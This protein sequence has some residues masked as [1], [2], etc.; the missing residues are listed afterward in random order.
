MFSPSAECE[1][2]GISQ[3]LRSWGG[4]CFLCVEF[5]S[6]VCQAN[7]A[8]VWPLVQTLSLI[9]LPC[10][11]FSRRAWTKYKN[12]TQITISKPT[13][14]EIKLHYLLSF[15]GFQLNIDLIF[16]LQIF[17]DF[18]INYSPYWF[19]RKSTFLVFDCFL[20][21]FSLFSQ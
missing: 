21:H 5:L 14:S 3:L 8:L 2:V 1:Q 12:I 18:N 10:W 17:T 11:L 16:F 4:E 7:L 15:K 19:G 20:M 6:T 9:Y 13:S